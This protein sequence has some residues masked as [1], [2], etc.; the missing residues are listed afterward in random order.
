MPGEQDLRHCLRLDILADEGFEEFFAEGFLIWIEFSL[1]Q[2]VAIVAC[3]VAA[4]ACG[5]QHHIKRTS[6]GNS[7]IHFFLSSG[8]G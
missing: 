8:I 4:G 7:D 3:E 6:K 1:F 5:L 2:I